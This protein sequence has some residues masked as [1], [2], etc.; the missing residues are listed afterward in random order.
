[1]YRG[2]SGVL[3]HEGRLQSCWVGVVR[4]EPSVVVVLT[5]ATCTYVRDW[6][7]IAADARPAAR[8]TAILGPG[9]SRGS[10]YTT[11]KTTSIGKIAVS[12]NIVGHGTV[13]PPPFS[14]QTRRSSFVVFFRTILHAVGLLGKRRSKR[15]PYSVDSFDV[16]SILPAIHHDA[17]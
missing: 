16:S 17:Q 11:A 5:S 15:A 8:S 3:A 10:T 1:L 6:C 12:P 13:L 14:R 7:I 4:E 9:M 2:Q